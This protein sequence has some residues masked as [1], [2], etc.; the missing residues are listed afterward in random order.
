MNEPDQGIP[1]NHD[2]EG[3][4]QRQAEAI[5]NKPATTEILIL[6]WNFLPPAAIMRRRVIR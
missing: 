1:L 3:Q 4:A 2:R 6:R 5:R